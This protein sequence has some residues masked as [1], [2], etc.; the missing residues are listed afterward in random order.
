M[1]K[2]RK[3]FD[4]LQDFID[5]LRPEGGWLSSKKFLMAFS[6]IASISCWVFLTLYVNADS[7]TTITDIPIR[8]D[9]TAMN[10]SFGLEMVAITAPEA[11]S[12]GKVDVVVTGSA[13]QIS[14]VTSDDITVV[15]QTSSVNKAGEYSLS[16]TLSC[17]NKDVSVALKDSFKK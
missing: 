3:F 8:I 10:E 6:L 5:R 4:K 11:I 7:Q 15:A 12:D 1:E 13:Y 16:L 2:I 9:T 17:G 14:R